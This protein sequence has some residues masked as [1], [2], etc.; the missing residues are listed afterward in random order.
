MLW[1]Q[2]SSGAPCCMAC[3][4]TEMWESTQFCVGTPRARMSPLSR[5]R[6]STVDAT[7]SV[8]GL[9]PSTASPLP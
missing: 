9:T 3:I 6:I 7:V 5:V 4:C 1:K 2:R 8:E